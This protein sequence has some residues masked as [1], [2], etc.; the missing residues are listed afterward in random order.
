[1][2]FH[3]KKV[4]FYYYCLINWTIFLWPWE[5]AYCPPEAMFKKQSN[6][7][8]GLFFWIINFVRYPAKTNLWETRICKRLVT[9]FVWVDTLVSSYN[10]WF[11]LSPR[12]YQKRLKE[13]VQGNTLH[14]SVVF[15]KHSNWL[16]SNFH[17]RKGQSGLKL[18]LIVME[19]AVVFTIKP[20][21][22]KPYWHNFFFVLA[23]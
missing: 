5:C 17:V 13:N 21:K 7:N 20:S 11:G 12:L 6:E 19:F 1:M 3:P 22:I 8:S 16:F 4:F 10:W 15:F 9:D 14:G 23:C 18:F 2:A